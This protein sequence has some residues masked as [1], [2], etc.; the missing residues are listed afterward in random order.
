[1]AAMDR[2]TVL[3]RLREEEERVATGWVG[4]KGQEDPPGALRELLARHS[5]LGTRSWW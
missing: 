4:R 2:A 5:R 3:K 1:M